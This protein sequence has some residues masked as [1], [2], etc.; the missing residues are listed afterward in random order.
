MEGKGNDAEVASGR[1]VKEGAPKS[2]VRALLIGL[3][4]MPLNSY[5]MVEMGMIRNIGHPTSV[6]LFFNVVFILLLLIL[7]NLLIHRI[8]PSAALRPDELLIIY[9]MLSVTSAICGA[10]FLPLLIPIL[11]HA[12]WYATPENEWKELFHQ[13]IPKWLSIQDKD[14]LRGYYEGDSTLYTVG[15]LKALGIPILMW[16]LFSFALVFAMLCINTMIRKRWTEEER[17]SYPIVQLPLSMASSPPS[18]FRNRM[19]LFGILLSAG[20]ELAAGLHQIYPAV[21]AISVAPRNVGRYFTE[22]PWN[23]LGGMSISFYPFVIGLGFLIPLNLAF[24]FW[25]FYLFWNGQMV[26]GSILGMRSIP[27]FPYA[28]EQSIGA[29]VSLGL[30]A[31]WG[32]RR[33]LFRVFFSAFHNSPDIDDSNEALR[34]RPL[35][36]FFFCGLLFIILFCLRA[37]M[38]LGIILIFFSIYLLTCLAVTRIRAELGSP[39]HDLYRGGPDFLLVRLLGT[40]RIGVQNLTIFSFFWFFTRVHYSDAMPHQLEGFKIGERMNMA[41]KH[42]FVAITV[43][44]GAGILL[45]FWTLLYKSYHYG[46]STYSY[47]SF[48]FG[49]EAWGRLQ[50]W[51]QAPKTPDYVAVAFVLVGFFFTWFLMAMRSYFVWWPFHP[52]GY[53]VSGTWGGWFWFPIL[54]A[55]LLKWLILRHGGLRS[56]R[57]AKPFFFGLIIGEFFVMSLWSL[58]NLFFGVPVFPSLTG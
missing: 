22:K 45:S 26:I 24:S 2:I 28:I 1:K 8:L 6:S 29:Y 48:V 37:G 16:A 9:I 30:L 5:W 25:F 23:A 12:F 44:I 17:L 47:P 33:H 14:A 50:W 57:K 40:R 10:S 42:V 3:L 27:N 51:L 53:V 36:I 15:N 21:P 20:I 41:N 39:V 46:M 49:Q 55:W 11:G 52:V 32:S 18:F 43:A 54:I 19:L 35:V 34:Y 13:Y 58:V 7:F 31:I 4:L 38:T 56:H